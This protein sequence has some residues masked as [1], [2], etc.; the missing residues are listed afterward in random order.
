MT[1]DP[2]NTRSQGFR[3]RID[4]YTQTPSGYRM[5]GRLP[6]PFVGPQ[7]Y[8]N[9]G[10]QCVGICPSFRSCRDTLSQT[11]CHQFA[12]LAMTWAYSYIF[13]V[14]SRSPRDSNASPR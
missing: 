9:E 11:F 8:I 7:G 13:A 3:Y 12:S 2:F 14:L 6:Q 4:V 10:V 5:L 1:S